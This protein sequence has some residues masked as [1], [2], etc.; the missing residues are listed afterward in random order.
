M[1]K[2]KLGVA[3]AAIVAL[4]AAAIVTADSASAGKPGGSAKPSGGGA[5]ITLNESDP[6]LGDTVTFSS[7]GG[8]SI[9]INCFQGGLGN[10]VYAVR[11]PVGTTFVLGGGDSAWQSGPASCVVYLY[12]RRLVAQTGF[13]AAGAR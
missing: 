8:S 4:S 11:Q 10:L 6:H 9:T 5:S 3:M 13:E 2:W 12:G 7:S 1:S